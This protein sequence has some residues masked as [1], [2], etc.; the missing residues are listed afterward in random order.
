MTTITELLL[1]AYGTTLSKRANI[2][3][4]TPITSGKLY[5]DWLKKIDRKYDNA[6]AISQ[7]YLESHKK[8]VVELNRQYAQGFVERIRTKTEVPVINP[9]AMPPIDDWKDKDWLDFWEA[10]IM[11][12]ARFVV[13]TNGWEYSNGCTYE[14]F[15]AQTYAVGCLNEQLRTIEL[16]EGIQLIETAIAELK[17]N[18]GV[19][20]GLENN[21]ALLKSLNL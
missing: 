2:Y 17:E 5:A 12:Y 9:A 6:D 1:S 19:T 21:L 15:V 13:L 11:T 20:T 10:V 8:E 3:C 7:H 4:S 14:F 16:V 18:N